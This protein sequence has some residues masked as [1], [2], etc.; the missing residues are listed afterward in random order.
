MN[1]VDIDAFTLAFEK[2]GWGT[3][4]E[5]LTKYFDEQTNL[6]RI[7]LIADI[8]NYVAGYITLLPTAE[9]GPFYGK[10][11]PEI[12]DFNVLINYRRKGI[13]TKLMNTV[14]NIARE[15]YS[16]ISLG[17]GLYPDYGAAQIMYVKRGYIPDGSGIWHGEKH[18]NPYENCRND[19]D[20]NLYFIKKLSL[21]L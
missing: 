9:T 7:V 14:E 6:K 19:D 10:N 18:L 11:I 15:K 20:L 1:V 17:V 2:Q 5:L 12:K 8:N 3:R 4:R 13:G 16:E 21:I